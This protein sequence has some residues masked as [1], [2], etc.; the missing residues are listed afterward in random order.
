VRSQVRMGNDQVWKGA[1]PHVML[2]CCECRNHGERKTLDLIH[3]H[4][5]AAVD[6]A[7]DRVGVRIAI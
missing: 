1:M 4:C 2:V 6:V 5:G 3:R 7:H